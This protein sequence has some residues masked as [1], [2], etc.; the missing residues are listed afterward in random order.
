M[1][2]RG[3]GDVTT[4]APPRTPIEMQAHPGRDAGRDLRR[5]GLLRRVALSPLSLS[6][7]RHRPARCWSEMTTEDDNDRRDDGR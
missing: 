5:I 4:R 1:H 6:L 2:I 7:E 3:R